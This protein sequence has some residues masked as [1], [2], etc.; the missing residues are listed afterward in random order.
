MLV[1]E[2]IDLSKLTTLG[3]YAIKCNDADIM[4]LFNF[5][6]TQVYLRMPILTQTQ[7]LVLVCN[8]NRYETLSSSYMPLSASTYEGRYLAINDNTDELSIR[9]LGNHL[10]YVPD[11]LF[12]ITNKVSILLQMKPPRIDYCNIDTTEFTLDDALVPAVLAYMAYT[13]SKNISEENGVIF[14]Q[15]FDRSINE[16]KSLGLYTQFQNS[17]ALVFKEHGFV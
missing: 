7:Q 17:G 9:H 11:S 2:V 5:A 6:L 3:S 14:L 1:R 15:E 8:K 12:E 13:V 10:I 4:V 16:V